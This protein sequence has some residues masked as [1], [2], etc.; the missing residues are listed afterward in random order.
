MHLN[1]VYQVVISFRRF[2]KVL[3]FKFGV[4]N[5]TV[6]KSSQFDISSKKEHILSYYQV[7]IQ[8]KMSNFA[9]AMVTPLPSDV[10]GMPIMEA[11]RDRDNEDNLGGDDVGGEELSVSTSL[12]KAEALQAKGMMR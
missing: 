4:S 10:E 12:T 8:V 6:L 1:D 7:K 5:S 9:E 3:H 2:N 11:R